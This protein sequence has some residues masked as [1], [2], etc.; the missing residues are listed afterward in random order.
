[1]KAKGAFVLVFLCSVMTAAGEGLRP[2]SSKFYASGPQA[3]ATQ[4]P[5]ARRIGAIKAI[6][7]NVITLTQDAGPEVA[8]SVQTSTRIV[9]VPPGEKTLQNATPIPLQD[10]QVGDRILVGGRASED[11]SS[12]TAASIVVMKRSDVEARQE[13]ERQDWQ[14]RGVDGLVKSVDP[15]SGTIAVSVPSFGG[16]KEI[17]VRASKETVIRR[18]PPG[19]ANF[20]EAKPSSLPEI[21]VNDQLHARGNRSADGSELAAEEIVAG[22]FRNVAGTI[23]SVDASTGTISVQDLLSKK[24][25]QVR[26]TADSQLRK[27]P[28][29]AARLVMGFRGGSGEGPSASG[30][31]PS[32]GPPGEE[33]RTPVVPP[34]GTEPGGGGPPGGPRSGRSFDLNRVVSRMPAIGVG[35]L[36]KGDVVMIV[37]T[38]GPGGDVVTKLLSGVES[39]LQAAPSASQALML[40][41]WNLGGAP[42]GDASP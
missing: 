28:A 38:E 9:R 33:R 2:A 1:M 7:G 32:A 35:D 8:V 27:L 23:N 6:N 39:V 36:H 16:A 29:D 40:T 25:V 24:S 37:A 30:G 34:G 22:S 13:Q 26:V 11:A 12:L 19:S 4:N 10:L 41:P 21:R 14:K 18:Y 42:G 15:A 31:S 17:S 20:A 5:V 3:Q